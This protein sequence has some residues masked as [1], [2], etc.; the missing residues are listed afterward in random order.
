VDPSH[1]TGVSAMVE[2]ASRAAVEFGCH[3]LIIEVASDRPGAAKPKCDAAQAIGPATLARI[4]EFVASHG[5][6]PL[7]V[8]AHAV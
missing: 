5:D 1:A 8:N 2:P 7:K 6:V 4:V 3:G